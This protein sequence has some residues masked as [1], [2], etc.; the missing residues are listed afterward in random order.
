MPI[1]VKRNAAGN[2]VNFGG[3]TQPVYWNACLSV[4]EDSG[5]PGT[6]NV[7]NEVRTTPGK[8]EYEYY[9]I[10]YTEFQD[11]DGNPFASAADAVTYLSE[12]VNYGLGGDPGDMPQGEFVFPAS[13]INPRGGV[14]AATIS[15]ANLPGT[16]TFDSNTVEVAVVTLYLDYRYKDGTDLIPH[17][18]W[19]KS[20]S[21]AGNVLWEMDYQLCPKGAAAGPVVTIASIGLDVD[22]PDN[23]TAFEHLEQNF[24]SIPGASLKKDDVVIIVIRRKA[25]DGADTYGADAHLLQMD[26]YFTL[27]S[28]V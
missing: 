3:A 10:P 23:N 6:I 7:I 25:N 5:V 24:T 11:A 2:C 26:T 13:G 18:H 12:A 16:L 27:D 15:T 19:C 22:T 4:E 20:T 21:A 28:I 8:P 1:K 14:G 17:L 9:Q